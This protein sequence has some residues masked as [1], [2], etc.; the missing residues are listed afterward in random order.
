MSI[1]ISEGPLSEVP[2]YKASFDNSTTHSLS[3]ISQHPLQYIKCH[4]QQRLPNIRDCISETMETL[5]SMSHSTRHRTIDTPLTSVVIVT[6]APYFIL[7][8]QYTFVLSYSCDLNAGACVSYARVPRDKG[9]LLRL[10]SPRQTTAL[11][12]GGRW[13]I[14]EGEYAV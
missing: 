1:P 14:T 5:L 11:T 2:L 9:A 10:F 4:L 13:A 8:L 7:S 12:D 6:Y 3:F